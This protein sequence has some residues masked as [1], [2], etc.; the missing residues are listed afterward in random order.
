MKKGTT[1]KKKI[2]GKFDEFKAKE[3]LSDLPKPN[4]PDELWGKRGAEDIAFYI[5]WHK[6]HPHC[7]SPRVPDRDVGQARY[8]YAYN[9]YLP[10]II[11][12][13]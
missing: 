13:Y 10:T 3:W 1:K 9:Y 5:D 6:R 4:V 8:Y 7:N 12:L 2:S 11:F